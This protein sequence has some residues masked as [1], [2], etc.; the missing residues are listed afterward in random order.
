MNWKLSGEE[1]RYQFTGA[2]D[3]TIELTLYPSLNLAKQAGHVVILA[4]Y[5]DQLLFTKHKERG[6][7]WPGGKVEPMETPLQAAIRELREET[8]G[9][10]SS[11]WFLGQYKVFQESNND[12]FIKNIYVAHVDFL[13]SYHTGEDTYGPILVPYNVNPTA[14]KGFS[15]LVTDK[16]FFHVR[17]SLWM[18]NEPTVI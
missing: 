4:L 11:I 2:Y 14:E 10:A 13:A 17:N 8:G 5:Q 18:D 6:V 15:P 3:H 16:V 1:R 9:Q 7:E 12:Y